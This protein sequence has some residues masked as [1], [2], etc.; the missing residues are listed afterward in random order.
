MHGGQHPQLPLNYRSE[1]STQG[2]VQPR[3]AA[4]AGELTHTQGSLG[5]Y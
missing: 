3:V 2:P 5:A 4:R 1:E